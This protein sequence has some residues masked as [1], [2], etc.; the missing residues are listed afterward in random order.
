VS[1][2][3]IELYCGSDNNGHPPEF[4]A[5]SFAEVAGNVAPGIIVGA[6]RGKR[7]WGGEGGRV[8]GARIY[9]A[10]KIARSKVQLQE[11][12]RDSIL[13]D[14]GPGPKAIPEA[15]TL[16]EADVGLPRTLKDLGLSR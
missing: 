9:L 6:K 14:D 16:T 8:K 12:D 1:S 15:I 13:I 7:V 11:C 4:Q 3:P 5:A 2:A 10:G